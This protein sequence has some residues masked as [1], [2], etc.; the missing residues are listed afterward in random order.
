[1]GITQLDQSGIDLM[2]SFE[3]CVLH[4]YLDQVGIP[5]IGIGMTYYPDTGKKVTM[6][7]PTI[8]KQQADTMFLAMSKHYAMTIN[9]ATREDINQKQ[10]NALFSLCY[11]I[12]EAGYKSSTVLKLVNQYITGQPLK[13][14]FLMWNKANHKVVNDLTI[15]R[16]KE[17][18]IF[19]S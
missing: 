8:T 5:T 18:Q 3:G 14:A 4:P 1:M 10:F 2:I 11:N 16:E 13:D 19:I 7:D 6:S 12:G 17:Y 15:R 9:S